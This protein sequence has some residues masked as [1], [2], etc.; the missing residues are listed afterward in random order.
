MA[1][2]GVPDARGA[3]ERVVRGLPVHVAWAPVEPMRACSPAPSHLR[4]ASDARIAEFDAGR[5]CAVQALRAAGM[6]GAVEVG[7][8]GRAPRWP[9]GFVGSIAHTRTLAWAAV[10]RSDRL[11]GL[12]IDVER[13]LDARTMSEVGDVVF[14]TNEAVAIAGSPARA[15]A[16]FCAKESAFKCL[17]PV[18]G[19]VFDFGDVRLLEIGADGRLRLELQ[20]DLGVLP[21]GLTLDGAYVLAG[22]H[23]YAVVALAHPVR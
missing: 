1:T 3:C 15:T 8:E 19:V 20:R 14:R 4:G 16:G 2:H 9:E 17:A 5:R 23:V 21:R 10:A 13:V 11:R 22:K 6:E 18:A 12:G 7:V